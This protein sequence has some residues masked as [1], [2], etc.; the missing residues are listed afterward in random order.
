MFT[1][2]ERAQRFAARATEWNPWVL[3]LAVVIAVLPGVPTPVV[4][5]VAGWARMRLL[6]FMLL[7]LA[8]AALMTALVAGLGYSL[9]QRAVDVVL[10]IDRYASVVSLTMITVALLIPV[11]KRWIPRKPT[12]A[13]G[14]P[15]ATPIAHP[16]RS[17]ER[18]T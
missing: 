1:T 6:T 7:N 2:S 4:Y 13:K 5:A 8:G 3:R 12:P 15:A 18:E 14:Q 9:G 16:D 17:P 10:L 11:L